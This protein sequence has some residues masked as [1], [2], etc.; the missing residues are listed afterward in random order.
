MTV[1]KYYF[2]MSS[3]SDDESVQPVRKWCRINVVNIN[4]V[5]MLEELVPQ[6]LQ[7]D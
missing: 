4:S 5:T 2:A 3:Y 7:A 6:G 1:C